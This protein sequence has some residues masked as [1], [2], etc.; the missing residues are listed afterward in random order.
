VDNIAE[1]VSQSVDIMA[2]QS[3]DLVAEAMARKYRNRFV[4]VEPKIYDVGLFEIGRIKECIDRGY[5][6]MRKCLPAMRRATLQAL[7]QD[8]LI[9][10]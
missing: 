3:V 10:S 7:R 6:A 8:T 2:A 5:S 4:R 9:G 1:V